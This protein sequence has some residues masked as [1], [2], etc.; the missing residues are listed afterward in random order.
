MPNIYLP[1]RAKAQIAAIMFVKKANIF[2]AF[3]SVQKQYGHSDCGVFVIAFATSLCAGHS[4]AK[5]TYIQHLLWPHL[6]QYLEE[7]VFTEFFFEGGRFFSD[8]TM[9]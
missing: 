4:P 2:L 5:T 7:G 1:P 3:V 9:M 8:R 6:L